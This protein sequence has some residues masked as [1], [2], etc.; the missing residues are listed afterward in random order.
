[1]ARV[2]SMAPYDVSYW[3]NYNMTETVIHITHI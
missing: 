3:Y 1:M 2:T